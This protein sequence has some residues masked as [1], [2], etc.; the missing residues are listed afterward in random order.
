[1]L[2]AGFHVWQNSDIRLAQQNLHFFITPTLCRQGL[3]KH[4]DFL[5][6][7]ANAIDCKLATDLE[8]F[9]LKLVRP[10]N[11]ES[12]TDIKM[13]FRKARRTFCLR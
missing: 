4:H 1:M 5:V 9:G 12:C 13:E 2:A 8:V 11:Q 7:S 3:E 10:V 6:L